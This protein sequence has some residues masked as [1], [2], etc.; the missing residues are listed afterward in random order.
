MSRN[1]DFWDEMREGELLK[2]DEKNYE[3]FPTYKRDIKE[4]VLSVL[5]TGTTAN[6]FYVS[7]KDNIKAM[8][9]VL[10]QM[11]DTEY[12]AKATLY[13]R[14]KG[15][16]RTLPIAS[17]VEISKR[18]PTLFKSLALRICKNPHD[19]GQFIDICR[20]KQIRKG[21]GRALKE[22]INKAIAN[23]SV[24]HAMKYPKDVGDMINIARPHEDINPAVIKYI[25]KGEYAEGTQ[26]ALLRLLKESKTEYTV[27]RAIEQGR[28]PYEVVTGSSQLMT[29][30]IRK[31]MLFQAPYFNLIRN[32]N[33]F[34]RNDVFKDKA[35]LKYA[36]DK[37]IDPEAIAHSKLL[38]FRYWAAYKYLETFTGSSELGYALQDA[39]QTSVDN[40]PILKGRTAIASDVSGSMMS[41]VT[42][43]KSKMRCCD[44]VGIFSGCMMDRCEEPPVILPFDTDVREDIISELQIKRTIFERASLFDTYGGTS[45]SAPIEWLLNR[46][47]KVDTF[48]GITDN[49]EWVGR[50]FIQTFLEY[51]K[52]VAPKCKAYLITLLP[53]GH[54]PAPSSVKD[55]TLIYGWNEQILKYITM[56]SVNQVKEVEQLTI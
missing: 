25:K 34:G 36:I 21:V 31:A 45:L 19:W 55:V 52:K 43:D 39:L 5:T 2:T 8:L 13:A 53:Y 37:I 47:E 38:P 10:E 9:S 23:M 50:S 22:T 12:L 51:R 32:L 16:I 26:L 1:R 27:I 46:K 33:N 54:S 48:I 3:E 14:E 30:K 41:L 44:L 49:E 35:A 56:D 17:L 28:L 24:Y 7:A 4:Q 40:I 15:L 20:S 6:L 18:D 11:E 29:T 42:G